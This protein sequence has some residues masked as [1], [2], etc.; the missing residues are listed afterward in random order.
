MLP[1]YV[2]II[3]PC[4]NEVNFIAKFLDSLLANDY[5]KI[6]MEVLVVDG[7]SDDGT[8]DIIKSYMPQHNIISLIDNEQ[9]TTPAALNL[10]IKNAKGEVIMRMDVHAEYPTNY[11]SGLLAVLNE[12]G[13][14][15]VGGLCDTIPANN[16]VIGKA[17]A[18][19]MAHPFGV[20]NSY[21]RIGVV[22]PRWVDT[23]PFGCYR[24]KVFDRIGLF[25]EELIRNQD[26]ELNL[27]LIKQGGK[28]LLVPQIISN[29]YARDSL[30]NLG[31]MY[32]QYGYFKP[33]V[34]R[35]IGGVLTIR[36]I[37]PGAFVLSLVLLSLLAPWS[38]MA[39]LYD[40]ILLSAYTAA[41][42][43]A[44]WITAFRTK[45]PSA[46]ALPLVFPVVHFAYGFGY[47]KGVYEFFLLP[48]FKSRKTTPVDIKISR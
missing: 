10:G 32:F 13:A 28:I 45:A 15:N 43:S 21:F 24:R 2:S 39:L 37:V 47:L 1:P 18:M 12:T 42:L 25:D 8:R 22:E 5:S 40:K 23:V 4:R 26:D 31:R 7:M 48:L 17:I 14:D 46:F 9:K 36:Q 34:V 3:V 44:S 19:A 11:I 33:L 35:K 29:Y 16:S 27:R 20:G 41:N 30:R 38:G 6:N